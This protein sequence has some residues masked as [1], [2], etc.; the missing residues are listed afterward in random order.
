M[1]EKV[2]QVGDSLIGHRRQ[3][4]SQELPVIAPVSADAGRQRHPGQV[5]VG[6]SGM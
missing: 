2:L 3:E 1:I 6:E 5:P 4:A